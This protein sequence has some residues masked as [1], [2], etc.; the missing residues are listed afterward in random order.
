MSRRGKAVVECR[1]L[2]R[3]CGVL[4]GVVLRGELRQSRLGGAWRGP[5]QQCSSGA[6]RQGKVSRGTV[7]PGEAWHGLVWQSSQGKVCCVVVWCDRDLR[8]EAAE[9][10]FGDAGHGSAGTLR[11]EER[12]GVQLA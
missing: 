2:S 9:A 3:L 12:G 5:A 10:R 7:R 11:Q 4:R 8:G 6:A 1:G